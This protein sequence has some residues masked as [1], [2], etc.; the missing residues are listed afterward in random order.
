MGDFGKKNPADW[1]REEKSMQRNSWEKTI[2]CTEKILLMT[3]NAQKKSYTVM[4]GKKISNSK[5]VGKKLSPQLIHPYPPSPTNV[6]LSC[7]P[8]R[9]LGKKRIWHLSKCHPSSRV[10]HVVVFK[11]KVLHFKIENT[12]IEYTS[13]KRKFKSAQIPFCVQTRAFRYEIVFRGIQPCFLHGR[14]KRWAC[15]EPTEAARFLKKVKVHSVLYGHRKCVFEREFLCLERFHGRFLHFDIGVKEK[16]E[17]VH[18]K[19]IFAMCSA[20]LTYVNGSR[21]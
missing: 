16:P 11:T 2:S 15:F 4:W 7:Q 3:Y 13:G 5:G 20:D 10:H 8:F 21:I 1:F 19:L 18:L 14:P 6:R 17:N 9:G 12:P